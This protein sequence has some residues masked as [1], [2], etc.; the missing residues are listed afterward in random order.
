MN[1]GRMIAE[2][3]RPFFSLE[4]FPPSDPD[5]LSCLFEC[6]DV[7]G[8]FKPLFVSVTYGAG[9]SKSKMTLEITG[10]L[11]RRNLVAMA[12]LTCVGA[13]PENLDTYLDELTAA[14]VNNVLA[15]RG[16]PP[17]D[18]EW[19]WEKGHFRHAADLVDFIR[20]THPDMGIGVAAYPSPHPESPTFELD[21]L[22]T[23]NKMAIGAD[24][25][26]TQLFFDVREYFSLVNSLKARDID[27]P[28]IPGILPI[29]GFNALKRVL[30]LCGV[31]IPA[32]FYL[33]LEEANAKGGVEAVREAGIEFALRQIRQLLDFGAPGIHLYT[34]NKSELCKRIIEES[35]FA[36]S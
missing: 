19:D 30:A 33:G 36:A 23:A 11:A 26:I 4:F 28:V 6:A 29:Q 20:K 17:R 21:R 15:L 32:K 34:L 27:T 1:I 3:D 13:S 31:N 5:A 24:F 18:C 2:R 25:A 22:H 35:G 9:G 7:L 8:A 14:G 10:E 16:D 12:H